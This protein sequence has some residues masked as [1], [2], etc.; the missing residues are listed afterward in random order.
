MKGL[1]Q[2][3][4]PKLEIQKYI[5]LFLVLENLRKSDE[6]QYISVFETYSLIELFCEFENPLESGNKLESNEII[7]YG[8][9][10]HKVFQAQEYDQNANG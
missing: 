3:V 8:L 2:Y 6:V 10:T 9:G 4:S 7:F 1:E 5:H